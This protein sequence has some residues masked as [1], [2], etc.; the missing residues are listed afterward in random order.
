MQDN[1]IINQANGPAEVHIVKFYFPRRSIEFVID[2]AWRFVCSSWC[3][4]RRNKM[5]SPKEDK[6]E[7]GVGKKKVWFFQNS[8]DCL[9]LRIFL[10][11]CVGAAWAQ[12]SSWPSWIGEWVNR[13][14]KK[15]EVIRKRRW[16]KVFSFLPY[17]SDLLWIQIFFFLSKRK[18]EGRGECEH[19]L[20][21]LEAWEEHERICIINFTRCIHFVIQFVFLSMHSNPVFGRVEW[22]KSR[23]PS[24]YSYKKP[25]S[26]PKAIKK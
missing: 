22:V 19:A 11:M 24:T 1:Q 21:E 26:E 20:C 4:N 8:S 10:K 23:H 7:H 15:E 17:P 12:L 3:E 16:S 6:W 9:I 2:A 18:V 14:A 5:T 13:G 25:Y